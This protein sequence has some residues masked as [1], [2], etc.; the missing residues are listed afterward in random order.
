MLLLFLQL[1]VSDVYYTL[2]HHYT[3]SPCKAFSCNSSASFSWHNVEITSSCAEI[4]S[5][6]CDIVT[7]NAIV[8]QALYRTKHIHVL[9]MFSSIVSFFDLSCLAVWLGWYWFA[10]GPTPMLCLL[11][12]SLTTV[13]PTLRYTVRQ[14]SAWIIIIYSTE[15]HHAQHNYP[16]CSMSRA[17]HKTSLCST[18]LCIPLTSGNSEI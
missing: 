10:Q 2:L 9:G 13:P 14:N 7:M 1:F 3:N 11:S 6:W 8:T 12:S 5:S 16:C 4:L 15:W 18:I 17:Q